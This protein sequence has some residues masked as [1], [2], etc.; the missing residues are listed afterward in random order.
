MKNSTNTTERQKAKLEQMQKYT[1][2]GWKANCENVNSPKSNNINQCNSNKYTQSIFYFSRII[3][4]FIWKY[5]F[6]NSQ[7]IYL[8]I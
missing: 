1:I 6:Q 2:V 5:K 3:L 4:N 7:E 8:K